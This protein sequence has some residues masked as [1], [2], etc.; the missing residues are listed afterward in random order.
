MKDHIFLKFSSRYQSWSKEGKM[1]GWKVDP[2][3][4]EAVAHHGDEDTAHGV[5]E[6]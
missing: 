2:K 3:T 5:K 1:M 6:Y 4:Q